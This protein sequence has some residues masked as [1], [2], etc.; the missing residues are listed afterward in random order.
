MHL[1]GNWVLPKLNLC[2]IRRVR[3]QLNRR[4]RRRNLSKMHVQMGNNQLNKGKTEKWKWDIHRL[5]RKYCKFENE[6]A[7]LSSLTLAFYF[8]SRSFSLNSSSVKCFI[9]ARGSHTMRRRCINYTSKRFL[10]SGE[11]ISVSDEQ[12]LEQTLVP[13]Y[14]Y[15]QPA[16]KHVQS[17]F[18]NIFIIILK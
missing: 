15:V 7:F 13:R 2:S 10:C 5:N 4:W 1:P 16:V 18:S 8:F 17:T 3:I 12:L 11:F 6:I 9:Y 14:P